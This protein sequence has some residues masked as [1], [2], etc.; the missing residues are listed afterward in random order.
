MSLVSIHCETPSSGARIAA[1]F[2]LDGT[3][4]SLPSL[5]R[6]FIRALRNRHAIPV[7]NYFRWL[8]QAIRLAPRGIKEVIHANKAYLRNVSV[9]QSPFGGDNF[10]ADDRDTRERGAC[11]GGTDSCLP[12]FFSAA[13]DR[14]AWHAT[15]GHA[16]VLVTGTLAPLA[17]QAALSLILR[18][19]ARGITTNVS[20]CATQLETTE[21]CWTGQIRGQAMFGKTKAGAIHEIVA[22]RNFDLARCYAYADGTDDRWML[23]AVGQPSA[24][25]PSSELEAIARL[26]GWPVL[27]WSSTT[28]RRSAESTLAATLGPELRRSGR[29]GLEETWRIT[30]RMASLDAVGHANSELENPV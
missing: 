30:D 8:A 7:G 14:V 16:I 4:I 15:R 20:V 21:G 10:A 26:R 23:G 3:L 9:T 18:L 12:A 29:R 28:R 5:E 24:V 25:N 1:F 27:W 13:L 17:N 2:D 22:L 11:F 19:I 6:R